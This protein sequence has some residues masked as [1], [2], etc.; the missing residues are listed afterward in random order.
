MRSCYCLCLCISQSLREDRLPQ[1]WHSGPIVEL[2]S[3][4]DLMTK[5]RALYCLIGPPDELSMLKQ[6]YTQECIKM[7]EDGF[8][9]F[10]KSLL[11]DTLSEI[12]T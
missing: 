2:M 3:P 10:W 6:G 8:P 1:S 7:F 9:E 5:S 11:L 4:R 12:L